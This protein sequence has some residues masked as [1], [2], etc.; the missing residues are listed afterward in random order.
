M[1]D[2]NGDSAKES[3]RPDFLKKTDMKSEKSKDAVSSLS[4]LENGAKS[5]SFPSST[6][7]DLEWVRK[8]EESSGGFYSGFGKKRDAKRMRG[9][10]KG[11][12]KKQ[13]PVIT[14][15]MMI[16]GVGGLI[17]GAQLFQ[18]FS[19]VE[20][21]RETFNSMQTSANARSNVFF[22]MQMDSER[23]KNPIKARIF[24]SDTF[25]ITS[26]QSKRLSTQGIYY[27]NDFEGT[28]IRVLKF[29]D[30]TGE[31]RIVTA[32]NA[33]AVKLNELDLGNFDADSVTG[34]KYNV[35]AISFADLYG[36]N[37]DFF[38]G[39]N[40]GS[41][42]WRGAIANWFGS[43][44][45]KFL[46]SN[47]LTRNLFKNFQKEV[48]A[49]Q[50]G[51][52]KTVALAMMAEG[53]EEVKEGGVVVQKYDEE[54]EIKDGEE[55]GTGNYYLTEAEQSESSTFNRTSI[56][57]EADV[58]AKLQEISNKYSGAS[59]AVSQVANYACLA[60]NFLGGVS[61]L[62]SASEALQII[63]LVT[64]Y[65]EAIDKVRAGDGDD[66]PIN[67]LADALNEQKT[68]SYETI[69]SSGV[70]STEVTDSGI[71]SLTTE[72]VTKTGS[73]MESSGIAALYGG[74]SVNPNDPSVKSFNFTSSIKRVLG[75]I[76]T[77]MA[78]F[79][80]C[81]FAKIAAAAASTVIDGLEVAGCI[82]GV[83]GA[84][85]TFGASLAACG[86]FLT[87]KAIGIGLS[88]AAG[89]LIGGIISLITPVVANML[90]RD[91]ITNIGGEDLGNALTSGANMYLGNTHRS[92]GG[93]LATES[94]YI[95]FAYAQQ[96]TIAEN[97]KYERM[98]KSPFDVSSQYTF[99]GTL[100][101]QLMGYASTNSFMKFI[102]SSGSMISSAITSLTPASMAYNIADDLVPMDEYAEICPYLASIGAVGDMYCNP[103]SIT[104]MS[105]IE[106]DPAN[107]TD[108]LNDNFL[109]ETTEDGN[110]IIDGSSDLAKYILFCD[111]RN[112]AFGIAD[113]NIVNQVS[114][115]G[116]VNS[117]NSTFDNV[118][119]SAIGAVPIVGDVIDI[120]DNSTALANAGYIGGES[121]VAGNTVNDVAAPDWETAKYY[122][123]FIEDQSLAESIGLIKESA[124][125]AYL[126]DYYEA[127]PLDQSYEGILARYSGLE[128]EDVI[129]LLDI[130]DY[131]NYIASYDPSDR[132]S[133][134]ENTYNTNSEIS[135]EEDNDA[136]FEV[137]G[138]DI[139]N[140]FVYVDLR[141]KNYVA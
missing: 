43:L 30:G 3:I 79:E 134:V 100:M 15:F 96:Q 124:V 138:L 140:I 132:Y 29:D 88:V 40:K 101:T 93:S 119:N 8:N 25:K 27:D 38:Y 58:R 62:V 60:V 53:T 77:S 78:A 16:F 4:S 31:L 98:D 46:S 95:Q 94:E 47:N 115:W 126:D 37:A 86:P 102:T 125:T 21:F 7:E 73:A 74:G 114:S 1:V 10:G 26:T 92:N 64:N 49:S 5:L 18:P 39:Y 113:Q 111:N 103:Y 24:S 41:M 23:V 17:G 106:Y 50:N 68:S 63:H 82:A 69:V 87:D 72:K 71:A 61:L 136:Q 19:L 20:Q 42:T 104:D 83:V 6:D 120:V 66:S 97:A 118:T 11:F 127:N 99:L 137:I 56:K 59:G 121:C 55:V 45:A 9:K 117:G 133:F 52:T 89:V 122:Q 112:S 135:F 51:N 34:M 85:F 84:G 28:G 108:K 131:G 48:E 2:M 105:T 107:V 141:N 90:T 123:R 33:S 22:K 32:D 129:A 128:K 91:L 65:F 76:G 67:V 139:Y 75:G 44:T 130:I 110:V 81:S 35:E 109:D 70:N 54:T 80:T 14:I 57:S 12:L 36:S 13:G 116:Q